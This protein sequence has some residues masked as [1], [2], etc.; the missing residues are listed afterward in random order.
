MA[1][2]RKLIVALPLFFGT[3][4]ADIPVHCLRH[5]VAGEWHFMLAPLSEHRSSCGHMRPDAEEKQPARSFVDTAIAAAALAPSNASSMATVMDQKFVVSLSSP[6]IAKTATD[7]AGQ[8]TMIY[9]EGFEV[10]IAGLDFLAFSNFTFEGVGALRHNVSHCGETMV[11]WY[12]TQDRA[13]FGCF[14]GTKV[15][16]DVGA[17]AT[18]S[19]KAS[20]AMAL[21][22]KKAS[23]VVPHYDKPLDE[24]TQ[25]KAVAKLN[26]KIAMLQ[27]S[28]K[29]RA[30][31]QFN[32]RTMREV[33]GYAGIR[34][35]AE[36]K[37]AHLDMIKQSNTRKAP[38]ALN[39]LQR[40][41]PG[42]Q[43]ERP[44]L[45]KEFDWSEMNGQD[46]L[47][48]VMDQQDCG[49]CYAASGMRM[50]TARH[51]IKQNDTEVLPW[52]INFPLFCAE[53]NQ[54]CKGGFGILM[55]KWSSDVGL[56]PATC[57]RY[58][59]AGSCKLECD[60]S[61]L[62]GKRFRAAN[63]RYVGA[64][65]GNSSID[66]IKE[67][68]IHNGPLVLGIEP[69]EDFMFYSEGVFKSSTKTT[70]IQ[71]IN[72]E[73]QRIDH[74]VLLVGYGVEDGQKYWRIQ[75]SWG[76]DWGEDGFFRIAAEENESGIESYPEAADVV[77][78]EQNGR[79]VESFFK[80]TSSP[81]TSAPMTNAKPAE[82]VVLKDAKTHVF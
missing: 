33:N 82:T 59:T 60:L 15:S 7:S 37:Q 39:F 61:S 29:A 78:D 23:G 14:Y 24:K 35:S 56:L 74:A 63:Q 6:N 75:N 20:P 52:S 22:A 70:M 10:K 47:E 4:N 8:W 58:N 5:E 40:A 11:G 2:S 79:Q 50:L 26:K 54:G 76:P 31:P 48:P 71:H 62:K 1:F 73:W 81:L 16:K 27:L 13:K 49:S 44:Q 51:K 72:A 66:A 34:R 30:M 25:H 57:M 17:V 19:P 67:E 43:K 36:A 68:L 42:A 41:E 3:S 69:A 12:Q 9:D 28:W 46:F 80:Q 38:S 64:F 65:Y 18:P 55:S 32:G 21:S 53:F 77:E 45:P